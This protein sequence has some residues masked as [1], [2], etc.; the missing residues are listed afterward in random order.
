M[1]LIYTRVSTSEQAAEDKTSLAE[2]ERIGRGFAMAKGFTQFDLALYQDPGVSAGIPLRQRPA[3]M[4]LL[5]DAKAGDTVFA[6]KFDRM[7]RSARDA[8]NMAEIFKEKKI[9]LVLFNI[10]ADPVNN[11]GFGEFFFTIMAGVAQL[12]RTLIKERMTE[13]KRAKREKG[14]AVGGPAPY[15]YRIIGHGRNARLE[16]VEDEQKVLRAVEEWMKDRARISFAQVQRMLTE[17]GM[18]A[19]NGQPFFREQV[20]RIVQ[21]MPPRADH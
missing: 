20:K 9:A 6:A 11:N 3:G 1:L 18:L 21:R 8:L 16:E 15:G 2:Q 5:E 14:G 7:F 17:R 4:R 19:R 10:G 13:G 12:E